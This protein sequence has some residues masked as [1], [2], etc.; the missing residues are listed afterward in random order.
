M[1]HRILMKYESIVQQVRSVSHTFKSD[2]CLFFHFSQG[3]SVTVYIIL[4]G[5]NIKS[6]NLRPIMKVRP[7]LAAL[8][9][10]RPIPHPMIGQQ[11]SHW[12]SENL[13]RVIP[14]PGNYYYYY[15]AT[16][17]ACGILVP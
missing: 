8:L 15:V 17:K 7:R 14:S 6:L 13:A 9:A 2:K 10:R 3:L 12:G 11:G 1:I 5:N 4:F 16:P